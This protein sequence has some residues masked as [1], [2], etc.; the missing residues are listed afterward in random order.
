MRSA[1]ESRPADRGQQMLPEDL[2]I[3]PQRLRRVTLAMVV[4]SCVFIYLQVFVPPFTPRLASGDQ[5]IY[6]HHAT[7]MLDGELIYRDYDH[8]TTPGTDVVYAALFK[9]FGVRAWI[10]QAMLILIGLVSV[11]LSIRIARALLAD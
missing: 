5:A 3:H 2:G 11:W 9:L 1:L 10:P 8:F 4:L 6:L 7:R